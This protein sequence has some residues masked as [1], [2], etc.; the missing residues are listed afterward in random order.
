MKTLPSSL[1]SPQI[2]HAVTKTGHVEAFALTVE[3]FGAEMV[4]LTKGMDHE[5]AG[6]YRLAGVYRSPDS[7]Y[8]TFEVQ[9]ESD[10]AILTLN[11]AR[12]L[13]R[14]PAFIM[15]ETLI[16]GWMLPEETKVVGDLEQCAAIGLL[17]PGF[18]DLA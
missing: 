17:I 6:G 3:N 11:T 7:L 16:I 1:E 13:R 9:R 12:L 15:L 14:R 10:R 2:Q 5:P 18:P 8:I 4:R